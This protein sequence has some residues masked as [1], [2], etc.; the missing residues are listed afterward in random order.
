MNYINLC[1]RKEDVKE[2]FNGTR[3]E[4]QIKAYAQK[5]RDSRKKKRPFVFEVRHTKP[6]VPSV[7]AETSF[8]TNS[9]S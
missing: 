7:C 6:T 9:S 2:F 3:T 1:N 8:K 5:Y 4:S